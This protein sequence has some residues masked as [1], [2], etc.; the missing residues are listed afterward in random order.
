MSLTMVAI[1]DGPARAI[2][3]I[4]K[5]PRRRLPPRRPPGGDTLAIGAMVA[6]AARPNEVVVSSTFTSLA[7]VSGLQFELRGKASLGAHGEWAVYVVKD[8]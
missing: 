4:Q 1:F 3:C 7:P 6:E 5:N 8:R 2:G